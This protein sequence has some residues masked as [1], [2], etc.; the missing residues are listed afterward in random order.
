[1]SRARAH[2]NRS[3]KKF[4]PF[5]EEVQPVPSSSFCTGTLARF[6]Q[7]NGSSETAEGM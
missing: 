1:M 2:L 5:G 6:M 7:E 4:S 3:E